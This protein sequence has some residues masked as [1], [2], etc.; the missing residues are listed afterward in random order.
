M[1]Y[2]GVTPAPPVAA[3]LDTLRTLYAM[4]GIDPTDEAVSKRAYETHLA[5]VRAA[6][7]PDRLLEWTPGD[8]W[9]PL[10]AAL[11]RRVP[12]LPFPHLNSTEE[13]RARFSAVG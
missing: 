10:C 1:S 4:N 5:A 9:E 11:D 8:G 12:D 3:A 13:F 7:P 6:I 2:Y